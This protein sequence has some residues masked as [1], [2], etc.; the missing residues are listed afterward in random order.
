MIEETLQLVAE[1]YDLQSAELQA[2][3]GERIR[4]ILLVASLY[5]SYTLSEGG[6]LSELII[7]E[8][9]NLSLSGPPRITRVSTRQEALAML[10]TKGCDMV[11]TMAQPSDMPT[12][13]F[14]KAA[15]QHKTDLPVYLVAYNMQDLAADDF[16]S[17]DAA[18]IDRA[19]IWRGDVRLFLAIIKLAEDRMNLRHD[20][21]IGGVRSIILVEDSL[22]FYSSY[23]PMLFS[24][25]V[26][27]T[28]AL[29][30]E[31]VNLAQR[32]TRRRM[33]PKVLL[34][35][36]YEEAWEL[37]EGLRGT[38]LAVI[39]D[40]RFPRGGAQDREAGISL[41]RRIRELD[42]V[43]PLALQTSDRGY[44]SAATELGAAL[45]QKQSPTLLGDF[46]DFMLSRLGFGDFV[47]RTPDGEE[48]GRAADVDGMLDALKTVPADSLRY[49][50][51]RNHF[52]NWLMARTEYRLA[53]TLRELSIDDFDSMEEIR[54][55]LLDTWSDIR[56]QKRR[57]QVADFDPQRLEAVG[58]FVRIG[59]G[60]LG[61]KGRGLAFVYE[62]LSR[63]HFERALDGTR[64][65][66]PQS[67]V[68]GTDAFDRFVADND[69]VDF[70]LR[71]DND[72]SIQA[73]FLA[74]NF[75][76][77]VRDD[78]A[79][80]LEHMQSPIAV[81]SSS[82]LED[83]RFLPAAGIYP[84][85]LLPNDDSADAARLSHVVDAIKHI[86]AST[87]LSAAKSYL[88]A[89]PRRVEDEKMAVVIQEVIGHRHE[90]YV[91]P[92]FSGAARSYNCYPIRDMKP[93]EG[94]A[95]VALG[96][97]KTVVEGER[98]LRFAPTHPQWLPQ[99][100]TPD[101]ILEFAQRDF[102]ALDMCKPP[103]FTNPEP[104]TNLVKLDLAA[105]ERHD[106]LWP[107]ASV[108]SADNHAVYDGLARPGTRLVTFA[109]ILKYGVFPLAKAIELLLEVG[110]MGMSGPVEIEFAA[111]IPAA[112]DE[113]LELAV[114]QIRPLARHGTMVPVTLEGI[115]ED[116]KFIYSTQ[117]LGGG[118]MTD[119]R[120]VVVVRMDQ[121][122]RARTVDIAKEVAAVN[123]RLRSEGRGYVLVG[124]GRWG[125]ADHWMGVP[126]TWY[127]INSAR[128]V[129]ETDLDDLAVEPSQ[130]THFFHNI[131]SQ[132]VAYFT[133]GRRIG[134]EVDWGWLKGLKIA[135]RTRWVDHYEL[136]DPLE[137][138]IN[139]Q[140]GEGAVL[141]ALR[142]NP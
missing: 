66:V 63:G 23:L 96:L 76:D 109:P 55:F 135:Q 17:D 81:R 70:A 132:G 4:E 2:L 126:V 21:E 29:I 61:G 48:V 53:A 54:S 93:E 101:D 97:G 22:A 106:T 110:E 115:S 52:S 10:E 42:P 127:Q 78:I 15:K 3:Q 68:V 116:E 59:G 9:H 71:E 139:G 27:Q 114:L 11:I 98:A 41:L 46:R 60:S 40:V 39:S 94:I 103:D 136:P 131:T 141:K 34:A 36:T 13:D 38:V 51:E 111:N 47:F 123:A 12:R 117:V 45:L 30:E 134:G 90:D 121:F 120:D 112:R 125:S 25:L 20:T 82:L 57:G 26:K 89:T 62:L 102:W 84:T 99:F 91:Y 24:E 16:G 88:A 83:S 137:V 44:E 104:D 130:G 87:F 118:R 77:D 142:E 18:G 105:A 79:A 69:L 28:E 58:G 31:E 133:V 107:V 85:H 128:V 14:A 73:R 5:D 67:A 86:Y 113:V 95:S 72:R 50:A 140:T 108:Y 74:A 8:Y 49:H 43:V 37:Y 92:S 19:F 129:V 6:H 124:P 33:R 80:F 35:T 119:V 64:I 138:L 56:E 75:P 100:S 7:G 122:D 32:L 65:V 1:S